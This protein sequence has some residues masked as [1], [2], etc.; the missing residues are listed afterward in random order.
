[1]IND[2]NDPSEFQSFIYSFIFD[3]KLVETSLPVYHR[4]ILRQIRSIEIKL[5]QTMSNVKFT[6]IERIY[7]SL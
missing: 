7:K 4:Q 2:V 5:D 1:M 6:S 3:T